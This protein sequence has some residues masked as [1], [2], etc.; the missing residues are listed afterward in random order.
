MKT[1]I[2][3]P[4]YNEGQTIGKVVFDFI[5]EMPHAE[6]YVYDNN[7]TDNT[8]AVVKELMQEC[9]QL[10]LRYEPR[11]GKGNV[12]RSMFRDIE[13]DCYIMVDGDDTY[14]ASFG[15]ILEKEILENNVDMAIGDRLSSTYFT[16]NK[17]RFHNFGNVLVKNL[18]N[19]CF[20]ADLHDIMTGAR[21]FSRDFVKSYAILCKGFEIETDMTIFALDN[22]FVLSEKPIEYRD[23]PDGSESKLNT[24]KDG[25]KVLMTIARLF[26]DVKPGEFFGIV[27]LILGI[28]SIGIFIP[29][30]KEYLITGLVRRFPTLIMMTILAL[31]SMLSLICGIILSVLRRYHKTDFERNLNI[32]RINKSDT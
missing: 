15:P 19:K 24:I 5:Q 29:I 12:V 2:L 18:V 23:R 20:K 25:T 1:A 8:A 26:R 9:K 27:S 21:A 31:S 16:E 32:V 6:I 7:S 30:F 13:A 4:C 17:R 10:H 3:I 28:I 22:N 11:Q 14:P